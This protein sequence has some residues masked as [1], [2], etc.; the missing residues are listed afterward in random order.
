MNKYLGLEQ[1]MNWE[2]AGVCRG[3]LLTEK[4]YNKLSDSEKA[5]IHVFD[6][7]GETMYA[8]ERSTAR[9]IIVKRLGKQVS[10]ID[11]WSDKVFTQEYL[12]ELN[13]KVIH[14]LFQLPDQSSFADIKE[15][16]QTMGVDDTDTDENDPI[17]D[18]TIE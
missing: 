12:E 5:K 16:E 4:E 8:E 1:F 15:I 13:E 14:P 7:N 9:G 2:N 18:A 3:N 6:F 17:A 10:F 11:F